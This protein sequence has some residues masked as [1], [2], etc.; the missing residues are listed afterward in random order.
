V[1]RAIVLVLCLVSPAALA[2]RHPP[3]DVR[4]VPIEVPDPTPTGLLLAWKPS[5]LSVRADQGRGGS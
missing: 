4:E 3:P 2:Q 5:I 1:V